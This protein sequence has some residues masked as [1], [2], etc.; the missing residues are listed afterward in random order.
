MTKAELQQKNQYL[1]GDIDRLFDALFYAGKIIAE[2]NPRKNLEWDIECIIPVQKFNDDESVEIVIGNR[3]TEFQPYVA[4]HCFNGNGYSWGH[5]CQTE[6]GA[7]E[8]AKYK[9]I[10]ELGMYREEC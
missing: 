3:H 1:S 8:E 10:K 6:Q 7:K 5:H 2:Q 9:L 4:W